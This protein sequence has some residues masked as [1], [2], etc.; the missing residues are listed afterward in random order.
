[1]L[2]FVPQPNLQDR[3]SHFPKGGIRKNAPFEK[4]S[5]VLDISNNP[6]FTLMI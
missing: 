4:V 1:M 6:D 2:G 3:R 5:N